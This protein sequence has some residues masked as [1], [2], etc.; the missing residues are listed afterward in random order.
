MISDDLLD[1]LRHKGE[2]SDLDYKSER[3]LFAKGSDDEKSELL[4]DILAMAN[5]HREGTSYI[6]I[7]FKESSPH[8]AELVGLPPEG[9]IDD[10]KLQQFVNSKLEKPLNFRYDEILFGGKN[11]A[12]I[13]IPNQKRPFYLKKDYG[14]LCKHV[15]YVRRGSSTGIASPNE[16]AMMGA[17]NIE[18]RDVSIQLIFQS[19]QNEL[20]P[21]NFEREFLRIPTDLP[22]FI[23]EQRG[24]SRLPM[25]GLINT[26]YWREGAYF[27][28]AW[29][30]LIRVRLS[31]SN[32]SSFS[33]R[34]AFLEVVCACPNGESVS[35]LR[36]DDMPVK[37]ERFSFGVPNQSLRLERSH[38]LVNVD[39]RGDNPVVY[40]KLGTMLPGQTIRAEEDIAVLPS[41]TGRYIIQVRV[42]ANEI[43]TPRLIEHAFEV[44]G[45]EKNI[46]TNAISSYAKRL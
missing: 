30:R 12:V 26:D 13:S 44:V 33:L 8:P 19:H 15:V 40:V 18:K 24:L 9:I 2:G 23:E 37:P 1:E 29:K 22:D 11:I 20:L 32:Y 6:L 10:A 46:N 28:S 38:R 14:R 7:G 45:P 21:D 39:N 35:L 3:Y 42:M 36:F 43:S 5:T 16:I 41:S 34:D 25:P 27:V 4:K 31:M 17:A